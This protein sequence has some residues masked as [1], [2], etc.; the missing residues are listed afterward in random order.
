MEIK[1]KVRRFLDESGKITQLPQKE[2]VRVAVLRCLSEKFIPDRYYTER[3]VNALCDSW[4]TFGDCFL[5]RRELVDRGLLCRK[6]DGSRYWLPKQA[7]D[8]N[9]FFQ[10]ED[11]M[12]D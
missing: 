5:L 2:S 11:Q 6:R 12:K 1:N 7:Q 8:N 3:E 10:F 4:H 9:L